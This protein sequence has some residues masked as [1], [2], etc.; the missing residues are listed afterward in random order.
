MRSAS[1]EQHDRGRIGLEAYYTDVQALDDNPWR[2]GSRPYLEVGAPGE[3]VLGRFS[4]FLNLE[5]ILSVRQSGHNPILR[6]RRAGDGQW[7]VDA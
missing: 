1:W 4:L 7:S 6:T 3:I 2:R 5:N